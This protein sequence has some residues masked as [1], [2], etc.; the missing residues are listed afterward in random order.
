MLSANHIQ[1]GLRLLF[2]N[3][4]MR[5]IRNV[6]HNPRLCWRLSYVDDPEHRFHA[7]TE[8]LLEKIGNG[9]FIV[10]R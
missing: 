8:E 5:I 4:E 7:K 10:L 9:K 2:H 6:Y 3:T 1:I